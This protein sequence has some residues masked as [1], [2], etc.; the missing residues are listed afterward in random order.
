ML[1]ELPNIDEDLLKR[2][3]AEQFAQVATSTH[4]PSILLLYGSLRP[5]SF[6]RSVM[7]L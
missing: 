2:P 7:A 1:P 6:S 3:A 5:R 4:A